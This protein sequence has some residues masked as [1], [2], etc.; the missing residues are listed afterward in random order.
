[1]YRSRALKAYRKRVQLVLQDP[2]GS[3]NPRHTV[4][5]RFPIDDFAINIPKDAGAT[6]ACERPPGLGVPML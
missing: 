6:C 3:L 5:A 1:G 4:S 2:S